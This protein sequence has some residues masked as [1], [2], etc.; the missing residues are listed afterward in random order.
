MKDESIDTPSDKSAADDASRNATASGTSSDRTT[1]VL[2][3]NASRK[4][5]EELL[6]YAIEQ[7]K[8][9]IEEAEKQAQQIRLSA[10]TELKLAK[11]KTA[12]ESTQLSFACWETLLKELQQRIE[13]CEKQ[14]SHLAID[15][16][17]TILDHWIEERLAT[18][19]E[20]FENIK[21][22]KTENDSGETLSFWHIALDDM[23][24][25][26]PV[27]DWEELEVHPAL[28]EQTATL[29]APCGL[30][31][32]ANERL[33]LGEIRLKSVRGSFLNAFKRRMRH[34]LNHFQNALRSEK[35]SDVEPFQPPAAHSD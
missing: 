30:Q 32:S 24:S 20:S 21:G 27:E 2:G 3:E 28:A 34:R 17:D 5:A 8:Q 4:Q 15:T 12:K 25:D 23:L 7:S 11:E 33:E 31:I 14:I 6:A 16:C 13:L 35:I 18:S 9:I 10:E 19:T 22:T 26:V 1:Q 29:L